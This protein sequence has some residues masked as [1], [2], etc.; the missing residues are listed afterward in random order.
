MRYIAACAAIAVAIPLA[1][2]A[3]PVGTFSLIVQGDADHTDPSIDEDFV[4]FASNASG[5]W[6][7]LLY[8]VG[9]APADQ[10]RTVAGGP[11]D[12]DQPDIHRSSVA[13][14]GPGGIF[15]LNRD[16]MPIRTPGALPPGI[17]S[18]CEPGDP[19]AEP[20]IAEQV[21][22]WECGRPGARDIAVA[23]FRS[24]YEEYKVLR[25][26]AATAAGDQYGPSTFGSLVAFVDGGD[27]GSVW[28]HE[29]DPATRST[30]RVCGG[31]ATGVAL[32]EFGRTVLAVT[33]ASS[34]HDEDVEIWDA[35][36]LVTTLRVD[37]EQRNPHLSGD[38]VA[39]EDLSTGRSQ[40]VLWQWTSGIVFVPHPSATNQS[41]NDVGTVATVEVR[42]VFA[43]DRDGTGVR[44]DI[45]LYQLAFVNGQLPDDGTG[46]GWPWT[47]PPDADPIRPQPASCSDVDPVVL[48]TLTLGREEGKPLATSVSFEATPFPGD[49]VLPVLIC[50]EAQHVSSAWVTLDDEAVAT[51]SSFN[52][53]VTRLAI[54]AIA[55]AGPGKLSGVIAGKPGATLV[56][57]VLADPGRPTSPATP[58][59]GEDGGTHVGPRGDGRSPPSSAAGV[60]SPGA[61]TSGGCGTGGVAGSLAILGLVAAALRRRCR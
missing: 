38:W 59:C 6:D 7:V 20:A 32:G 27:G 54:P 4:V 43:D 41:L 2:V 26:G 12:Q 10:L 48:A 13:F 22:A 45:A 61:P 60:A 42:V 3:K 15:I 46:S 18:A 25:P 53:Y 8:D 37:G 1:A 33:R 28:L 56:A 35:A 21:A 24:G 36:G 9:A 49:T 14:R 29:S 23:R 34:G 30:T 17:T 52:P 39:F 55:D 47:P 40:V 51:P 57:R 50:I 5:S 58:P 16:L 44:H 11:D 31:R 19:E